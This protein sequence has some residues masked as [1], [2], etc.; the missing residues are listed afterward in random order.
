MSSRPPDRALHDLDHQ[1]C[2]NR[3]FF[4]QLRADAEPARGIYRG[5]VQHLRSGEAAHFDSLDELAAFFT[6]I[7][8]KE[9]S[10]NLGGTTRGGPAP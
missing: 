1:A 6:A 2:T 5:R 10:D 8:V 9:P 7:S 3:R 4:I